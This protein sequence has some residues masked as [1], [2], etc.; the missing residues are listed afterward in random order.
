MTPAE[1]TQKLIAAT[2][3]MHDAGV[4]LMYRVLP[5]DAE[6]VLWD[7]YPEQDKVDAG[8]GARWFYHCH[9]P[10]ER[11]NGEHGHF[12]LFLPLSAMPDRKACLIAPE[13]KK[14]KGPPNVV[15]IAALSVSPDGVPV[16]WF[17]I[18]RWVTDEWLFPAKAII[19]ALDT[20]TFSGEDLVD[21]WLCAM[22]GLC[23]PILADLL[24]ERDA[25]LAASGFAGNDESLEIM[26]H[27]A[28]D[29]QAVVEPYLE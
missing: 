26:S 17:T 16:A 11:T 1:A 21:Q 23:R 7:H 14:A 3:A 24:E 25:K 18:N 22:V 10:E 5:H 2:V 27:A 9:P 4:P 19:A 29:L 6:P 20:W 12:H 8:S 15:H 13:R 28:F